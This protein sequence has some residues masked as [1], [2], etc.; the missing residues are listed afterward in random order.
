M[1]ANIW[2]ILQKETH[3]ELKLAAEEILEYGQDHNMRI[4]CSFR[5]DDYINEGIT[6]IELYHAF[7]PDFKV[8]NM[9]GD[10]GF[11]EAFELMVNNMVAMLYKQTFLCNFK[12]GD[13]VGD[14]EYNFS[15]AS[16]PYL[17][18]AFEDEKLS[19]E[20]IEGVFKTLKQPVPEKFK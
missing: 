12:L 17:D 16:L 8:T 5:E 1:K 13:Y 10:K 19:V 11:M 18:K 3:H 2:T 14:M 7:H 6:L 9:E 20:D 15:R 4:V